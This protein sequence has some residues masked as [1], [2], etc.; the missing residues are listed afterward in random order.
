MAPP[1]ERSLLRRD[2]G[3]AATV[4]R[5]IMS[6]IANSFVWCQRIAIG[7]TGEPVAVGMRSGAIT[8]K[9]DHRFAS[10]HS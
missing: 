4:S 3:H 7:L 1:R 2:V 9:N 8:H 6:P 10:S 5:F